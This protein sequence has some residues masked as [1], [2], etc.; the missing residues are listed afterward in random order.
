[1]SI[2]KTLGGDRLGSGNKQKVEMHGYERTSFN[3]SRIFR[4]TMAPGTLVPF[5]Q[6]IATPG[7]TFDIEVDAE[8][9][10]HPSIGPLFGSY[11]LQCDFFRIPMRLYNSL[12]HNDTVNI[13]RDMSQVKFP[14]IEL[15]AKSVTDFSAIEDINTYQINPS[16]LLAY[17]GIRGIGSNNSGND[18]VRRFNAMGIIGYWD[19]V[20]NYY[21]AKFEEIAAVIHANT[22]TWTA[23]NIASIQTYFNASF[24]AIPKVPPG[25]AAPQTFAQGMQIVINWT[26]TA[27]TDEELNLITFS[28]DRG[29]VTATEIVESWYVSGANAIAGYIKADLIPGGVSYWYN[30]AFNTV[31]QPRIETFPLE[32]I[33]LMKKEILALWD[34]SNALVINDADL[35]PYKYLYEHTNGIPNVTCSQEGLALKTY[36]SDLFNNWL[37]TENI[38]ALSTA[39]AINTA[40]GSFTIDTFIFNKKMYDLLMRVNVAGGSSD[41]WLEAVYAHEQ[42]SQPEKPVYMGGLIKE[43]VFQEVVSNSESESGQPLG[44]LAGKG[45]LAQKHKGGKVV[46]RCD[47]PSWIMAIVSLT[48]RVDYSQGNK[49]FV[50]LETWDDLHKPQFDQMGFQESIT[51]ERA[52]WDTFW[53]NGSSTW[54]TKSAGKIPAWLNYMTDINET[55]GNFAIPTNEMFM[56]LN[57]RFEADTESFDLPNIADLTTYI[58]PSKFNFIFAETALDAQNFWVQ[59]GLNVVARRK[60]SGKVMPNI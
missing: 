4:S 22:S 8:V 32:N 1:M 56:T 24:T 23:A 33:D 60:Q 13:G 9:N 2:T 45:T 50:H 52:H 44:T 53:D 29:L 39:T 40:G 43:V 15:T 41:D 16:S 48:P 54:V 47:E 3:V 37:K 18:Q 59:I 57:R 5:F 38:D 51:E 14:Q 6:Q 42:H 46:I 11:K 30:A 7:T 25:V 34:T 20:K 49:W 26:G 27:P 35:I 19:T 21:A 12:M 31:R 28:T 58:D 55:Y 17:L 10:T 36:Q